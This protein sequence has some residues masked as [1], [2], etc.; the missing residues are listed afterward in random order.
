MIALYDGSGNIAAAYEYDPFGRTQTVA[1]SYAAANPFRYSTKYTDGTP[2]T[3]D[4]Q[5]GLV[6]YGMRFYSPVL[7]RFVNRDPVEEKGGLNL[8]GFCGNDGID[9]YDVL[10]NW[11]D[12][13]QT[14]TND[15][16]QK[17]KDAEEA[18]RKAA[19]VA[20]K[21]AEAQANED[22]WINYGFMGI[23]DGRTSA[24][25]SRA[26]SSAYGQAYL[27]A[28]KLDNL[29]A[30]TASPMLV[31]AQAI[32]QSGIAAGRW[33]V[34]AAAAVSAGTINSSAPKDHSA[35]PIMT[36]AGRSAADMPNF[37]TTNG[38]GISRQLANSAFNFAADITGA[39]DFDNAIYNFRHGNYFSH[40]IPQL[41]NSGIKGALF[42]TGVGSLATKL[43][44]KAAAM[45]DSVA[46][47]LSARFAAETTTLYRAVSP[48]EA[49]DALANGLR[50]GPNSYSTGKFFA[51]TAEDAAKW[52]KALEGEGNFQLLK[53]EFP[54]T[55]ADQFMR[56][57]RL[58]SIGP[59]RFGTFEQMTTAPKITPLGPP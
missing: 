34:A 14:K 43:T 56:W 5:T 50:A 11:E 16:E 21:A 33:D 54:K 32:Y 25:V 48:A 51:E 37:G 35:D 58:D 4:P 31:S 55:T 30:T 53:V 45:F 28:A 27:G 52:G 6:Y 47:R 2:G 13:Y 44:S 24:Y 57:E 39:A 18:R 7:G 23:S 49:A 17:K 59:A 20:K 41:L 40:A 22:A 46:G 38:P 8:Y 36:F 9:S 12:G 1:G 10:G 19:E 29:N 3:S 42:V 15:E 26:G